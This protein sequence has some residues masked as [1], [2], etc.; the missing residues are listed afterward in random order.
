LIRNISILV[1]PGA[2][3]V[4]HSIAKYNNLHL[5]RLLRAALDVGE[6]SGGGRDAEGRVEGEGG[7]LI[8]QS[9]AWRGDETSRLN[10][11]PPRAR[12]FGRS[13]HVGATLDPQSQMECKGGLHGFAGVIL[14]QRCKLVHHYVG[15]RA[16]DRGSH[17]FGVE[18]VQN[19][20]RG[21]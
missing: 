21:A 17:G 5:G 8:G 1:K 13:L 20:G 4:K 9:L 14:R 19:D 11:V 10:D 18:R 6:Y 2:R 15:A 12:F 7:A 3:S 16:F